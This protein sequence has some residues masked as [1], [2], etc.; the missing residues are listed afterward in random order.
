MEY[1][2]LPFAGFRGYFS[3]FLNGQGFDGIYWSSSP[4][5]SDDPNRRARRL[6]LGSSLVRADDYEY[7]A[8]GYS[9]RCFK[10]TYEVPSTYIVRFLDD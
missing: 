7:R 8:H 10:D 6:Y 4:Y 9:V 2:K 1:F 5:G 3:A